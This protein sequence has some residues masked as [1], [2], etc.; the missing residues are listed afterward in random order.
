MGGDLGTAINLLGSTVGGTPLVDIGVTVAGQP[1]RIRLKLEGH[2]STGS[3]KD[4]TAFGLLRD[5][6]RRGVLAPGA[7]VVESTSGNL[8]ISLA[9]FASELGLEFIAVLDPLVTAEAQERLRHLG[10][11]TEMVNGADDNGGY[12]LSR[13]A[14]V[15]QMLRED[16][17]LVW[18]NQYGNPAAPRI[19]T[20]LTGPEIDEQCGEPPGAV[21]AAIST[22]GS[23]AGL[24]A[25]YRAVRPAT[26]IYGIDVRGSVAYLPVGGTRC[27]PGIGAGQRS[28]FLRRQCM[29]AFV[30]VHTAEAVATCHWLARQ[31][32][33]RVGGSSGAVIAGCLTMLGRD[34]GL[35]DAVCVCADD[36]SKYSSTIYNSDWLS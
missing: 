4:R 7:T 10:A 20:E 6:W 2:G 29:D 31:T 14:R 8:G 32:G 25:W 36:G 18:P 28:Q 12:L 19:H 23:L 21:F 13:L 9:S 35:T 5:L 33:I 11:E 30:A 27:I 22:G 24:S 17:S 15:Q 26:K 1:R 3:I 16:D 34:E